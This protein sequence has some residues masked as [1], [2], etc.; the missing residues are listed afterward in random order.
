MRI[1][2]KPKLRR[3]EF[4]TFREFL[5]Y[6]EN[7]VPTSDRGRYRTHEC[8]SWG[9]GNE[10]FHHTA[11]FGDARRLAREGW[12]EGAAK[13]AEFRSRLGSALDRAVSTAVATEVAYDVTGLWADVGRIA[14]G[15]PE[16]CGYDAAG[17]RAASRVISLRLNLSASA[18]CEPEEF[19]L[20]G[21]VI[22]AV[23]D[24]LES[25]GDRVELL[26]GSSAKCTR[27]GV[28]Y[29]FVAP[30]KSPD[31]PLDLDRLAFFVAHPS[32]LRRYGFSVYEQLGRLGSGLPQPFAGDSDSDE[33]PLDVPHIRRSGSLS[34]DQ[35]ESLVADICRSVGVTFDGT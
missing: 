16:C 31:Q 33:K 29:E 26:I 32:A 12:R 19:L 7:Q 11:T 15:E 35:F 17:T 10:D 24:T 34:P 21:A 1:I 30:A 4:A 9:T 18:S 27:T 6:A 23:V 2:E 28:T 14:T 20:R 22:A 13:V 8:R 25:L 3:A 5:D